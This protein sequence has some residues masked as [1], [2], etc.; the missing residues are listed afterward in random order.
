MAA[1][2]QHHGTVSPKKGF[3]GRGFPSKNKGLQELAV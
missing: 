2:S 1:D 3:E